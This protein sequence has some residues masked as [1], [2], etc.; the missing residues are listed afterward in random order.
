MGIE[1]GGA[2][3]INSPRWRRRPGDTIDMR[4]PAVAAPA[5]ASARRPPPGAG[6][7]CLL[8]QTVAL[9]AAGDD[10]AQGA[11]AHAGASRQ[12]DAGVLFVAASPAI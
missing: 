2:G 8:A 4:W 9:G 5:A 12:G 7:C 10:A 6:R 1:E 3:A 11:A